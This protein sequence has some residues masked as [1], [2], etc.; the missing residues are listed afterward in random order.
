MKLKELY[1]KSAKRRFS[2]VKGVKEENLTLEMKPIKR[3]KESIWAL[4]LIIAGVIALLLVKFSLNTFLVS[5]SLIVLMI[6]LFIYGN[7][8]KLHCDKDFV[9][10]KQGF[11]NLK[12]PYKN[13][14]NVYIGRVSGLLFFM[15]AFNYNIVVRFEDNFGFLREL[16]FSLLCSDEKEVE[17]F[18]NNFEV[19]ENLEERYVQFEKRKVWKKIASFI[20]TIIIAIIVI[21]YILPM[22]GIN[23]SSLI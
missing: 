14:R 16:E 8:S 15:P 5:L 20:F 23:I 9:S 3:L 17:K 12:I 18:I 1:E 11:Q 13:L 7:K 2:T 21:I 4:L 19:E 6:I 10:V 22:C